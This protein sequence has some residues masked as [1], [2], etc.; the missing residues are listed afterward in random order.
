M[1]EGWSQDWTKVSNKKLMALTFD[2]I[3]KLTVED[4]FYLLFRPFRIDQYNRVAVVYAH[5]VNCGT[6]LDSYKEVLDP[7]WR[8]RVLKKL[9]ENK[10]YVGYVFLLIT[11]MLLNDFLTVKQI[12]TYLDRRAIDQVVGIIFNTSIS[13]KIYKK[14]L[15]CYK[16]IQPED[17]NRLFEYDDLPADTVEFLKGEQKKLERKLLRKRAAEVLQDKP[18]IEAL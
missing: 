5:I 1:Q 2:D 8:L 11:S 13:D 7:K 18:K 12:Q 6:D 17:F 3:K 9:A 15:K 16:D 10:N 4:R 14:A